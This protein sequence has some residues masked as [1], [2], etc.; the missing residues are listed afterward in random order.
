MGAACSSALDCA[1]VNKLLDLFRPPRELEAETEEFQQLIRWLATVPF[2][3]NRLKPSDLPKLAAKLTKREF[4]SG[5][6]IAKRGE[7]CDTFYVIRSGLANVLDEDE[8]DTLDSLERG[9][10]IGGHALAESR[11]N[12]ATVVADGFVVA[13]SITREQFQGSIEK[14]E[15]TLNIPKRRNFRENCDA[16]ED[17]GGGIQE[18]SSSGIYPKRLYGVDMTNGAN[19]SFSS[20]TKLPTPTSCANLTP[21]SDEEVATVGRALMDNANLRALTSAKE[22]DLKPLALRAQRKDFAAGDVAAQAHEYG[23]EF[24]VIGKGSFEVYS[25]PKRNEKQN[26][27][28]EAVVARCE[29]YKQMEQKQ[30]FLTTFL[31]KNNGRARRG[32][33]GGK[34]KKDIAWD[35]M[36]LS[37]PM[38]SSWS[39][40]TSAASRK[41]RKLRSS[42]TSFF[43]GEEEEPM[44]R[45]TSRYGDVGDGS[46]QLNEP[47]LLA[48]IGAGESFGE[49]SLLY[50]TRRVATW[51]AAEEST[52]YV[53]SRKHFRKVFS[54]EAPY[55]KD[56]CA[57][58]EELPMLST[59]FRAER[60]ELARNASGRRNFKPNERVLTQDAIRETAQW[61][62]IEKG[63]CRIWKK[64]ELDGKPQ[65]LCQLARSGHFGERSI[66]R[67]EQ[68]SDFN[69]DA[70]PEG[71]TCFVVD[72]EILKQFKHRVGGEGFGLDLN[73]SGNEY[74]NR[75]DLR[76]SIYRKETISEL[77]DLDIL[78]RLGSGG[79]GAVYL[80][81]NPETGEQFALKRMSKGHIQK[82]GASKQVVSERDILST[83]KDCAFI[84]QLVRTFK[85]DQHVYFLLEKASGG[86]LQALVSEH[87]DVLACD[88]P[89]GSSAAFYVASVMHALF[90]LHDRRIVYRD[91]KLEN[92]L[93]NDEGHVKLCDMGFARFVLTKTSTLL[94]TPAC[95]AP[96]M[97][98]FPHAHDRMVDWWALG[99]LT[100]ELLSGQGPWDHAIYGGDADDGDDVFGLLVAYRKL[101]DQGPPDNLSSELALAKDFIKRCLH[102]KPDRRMGA[103]KDPR[104]GWEAAKAHPWFKS[105]NFDF[106]A[107]EA[108]KLPA[109]FRAGTRAVAGIPRKPSA[110]F[111][112]D[113][114]FHDL[115]VKFKEATCDWDS[116]F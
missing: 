5:D 114:G 110:A 8:T 104:D 23:D 65:E 96:E 53:I 105:L 72:G 107:L 108:C 12:V 47:Q 88:S 63:S 52:V 40:Q 39:T 56:F 13:H 89:R 80:A 35:D 15:F 86:D 70:G 31:N 58:L 84:I 101:H 6:I 64:T 18:S 42:A 10:F 78:A 94:G 68:A 83:C 11:P 103:A 85:D 30:H 112:Q 99:C 106:N 51:V 97:I 55:F 3:S 46:K 32:S 20:F 116:F 48:T 9:D 36:T 57:L 98:D 7:R 17:D 79:F 60:A 16:D 1:P 111:Q 76:A 73:C 77:E 43:K 37:M 26:T 115:Y 93:L 69:V 19:S 66:L 54:R 22:H 71:M 29:M 27:S 62:V 67:D 87:F 81:Q 102:L 34:T 33:A 109:P 95:M 113:G 38:G 100:F 74:Y 2:C 82:S 24:F 59:L 4:Y 49:L 75:D 44:A 45:R 21:L 92:V 25:E 91:L 90:F 50:N 28:A 61:Y 14:K 41:G